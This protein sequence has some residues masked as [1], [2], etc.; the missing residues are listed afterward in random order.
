MLPRVEGSSWAVRSNALVGEE[1]G[2]D[3]LGLNVAESGE[4][5]LRRK[6]RKD[7]KKGRGRSEWEEGYH[8]C[9]VVLHL[10]GRTLLAIL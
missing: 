10:V 4:V 8:G 9:R 7:E 5:L 3:G 1:D 6:E 2:A